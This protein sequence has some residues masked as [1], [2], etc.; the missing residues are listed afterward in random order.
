MAPPLVS[1]IIVIG[2]EKLTKSL[3]LKI[4][5][6]SDSEGNPGRTVAIGCACPAF[7]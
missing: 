6:Y 1:D 3:A 2:A 5:Q 7:S 4:V